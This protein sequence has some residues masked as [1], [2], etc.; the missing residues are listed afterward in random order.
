MKKY[1][2][3]ALLLLAAVATQ[4][5]AQ[6]QEKP[7]ILFILVDDWGWTD[8]RSA[9]SKYYETPNI[10][11]LRKEG[12]WFS[13]AY[14]VGPN[15]APSRASLM[16]GKYTPRHGIYTVGNADR[17]NS[18]DRKLIPIENNTVL[19]PAFVTIAEEL[20]NAGYSTGLI[21]KWQLGGKGKGADAHAQG[22]EHVIGGTGGTSAYFYP[23]N[24]DGKTSP[25]EGITTGQEGEY[26]TDR[27]TDEALKFLDTHKQQPFF[28]YL[29]YFAVHTPIEAK[30]DI[31]TKYKSK[32]GDAYHHNP[33]Y[34]A[35]IQS[36]DEGIGRVLKQLDALNLT[37]NTLVVFFS[38]NGG[39]GAVTAQHPL[40]GS[41]G[42]LYEGG[43]RV[44]LIVKWPGKT[45]AG[46]Q[47][48]SPVI[49]VDFYPTLLEVAS[50]QK[51]LNAEVDG[52]SFLP[53]L[54]GKPAAQRDIFWHFPAYLEAYKGDQRNKD[55]FRT[56]PVSTIRSG[57]FKLH[58]F[59]EDGRVELYNIRA[60]IGET[61]DLAKSNRAKT[62]ELK[63]KLEAWKQ[64][65]HAPVPTQLNP[66][67][68]PGTQPKS[69][70]ARAVTTEE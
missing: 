46:S 38:D 7:N 23:Y 65:T 1:L 34:A 68:A 22:F 20:K 54:S 44:P 18:V 9:G 19:N 14:S 37:E 15:C 21:G 49:G 28:L 29:S 6:T 3:K 59:Y 58:Q 40:R 60:D 35:M 25:H 42:M 48:D 17:G 39:M 64:K 43:V 13:Q 53:L 12:M 8:L 32:K 57:D 63:D 70:R 55:A 16:T 4:A 69:S 50:I 30:A 2:S 36:A 31:I 11:R 47:T 62:K 61:K 26:L 52:Q 66:E 27:L 56:R 51:P 10:D 41:K 67:Y 5:F 45:K 24:K 33:V